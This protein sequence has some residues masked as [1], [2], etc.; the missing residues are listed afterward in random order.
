MNDDFDLEQDYEDERRMRAQEIEQEM[1]AWSK[2]ERTG[3]YELLPPNPDRVNLVIPCKEKDMSEVNTVQVRTVYVDDNGRDVQLADMS[4]K[5][6]LELLKEHK[7]AIKEIEQVDSEVLS[8][9]VVKAEVERHEKVI[10]DLRTH[11]A[12]R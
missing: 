10:N 1:R 4:L 6:V 12:N 7:E 3:N 8:A 5:Q 11:L 9:P 2:N